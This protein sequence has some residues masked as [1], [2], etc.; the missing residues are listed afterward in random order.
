[1]SCYEPQILRDGGLCYLS[2]VH[3]TVEREKNLSPLHT[4]FFVCLF[5][6]SVRC[7][8]NLVTL[9]FP[10]HKGV[11][12]MAFPP[13]NYSVLLWATQ[14]HCENGLLPC[15]TDKSTQFKNLHISDETYVKV[16]CTNKISATLYLSKVQEKMPNF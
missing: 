11:N 5:S 1:M 7:S 13:Q 12:K 3:S 2:E 4:A 10:C 8:V 15:A 6:E 16:Q 14:S 9:I